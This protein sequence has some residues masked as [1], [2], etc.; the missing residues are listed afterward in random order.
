MKKKKMWLINLSQYD[1]YG[2]V[3]FSTLKKAQD[4]ER[5]FN[6]DAPE[7]IEVD[8]DFVALP[9]KKR[10]WSISGTITNFPRYQSTQGFN[11]NKEYPIIYVEN[12]YRTIIN[13]AG[14][15]EE[16][17]IGR[18]ANS[19]VHIEVIDES[20]EAAKIQAKQILS[21]WL[22]ENQVKILGTEKEIDDFIAEWNNQ[23][24]DDMEK[25]MGI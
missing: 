19:S 5:T 25:K 24:L 17:P 18:T 12:T 9:D 1:D 8:P 14:Y 2:F 16:I 21:N 13:P 7:E 15:R 22:V 23:W 11:P 10:V 3:L 6:T 4:Y 20:A